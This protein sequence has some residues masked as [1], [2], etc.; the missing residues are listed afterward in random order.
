M[1]NDPNSPV[2]WNR[3]LL[4]EMR[5]GVSDVESLEALNGLRRDLTIVDAHIELVCRDCKV[6]HK[7]RIA[8]DAMRTELI[9]SID[10]QEKSIRDWDEEL[11]RILGDEAPPK[12]TFSPINSAPIT[13]TEQVTMHTDGRE[14]VYAMS[15]NAIHTGPVNPCLR[16][17][18]AYGKSIDMLKS[19]TDRKVQHLA[20]QSMGRALKIVGSRR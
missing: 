6:R 10:A 20:V 15:L 14:E 7:D 19:M 8:Y 13:L 2:D 4:E 1:F 12:R 5:N 16:T 18:I 17:V 3:I 9:A 11:A